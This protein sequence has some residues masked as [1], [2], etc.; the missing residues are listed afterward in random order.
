MKNQIKMEQVIYTMAGA[1]K[2]TDARNQTDA[3]AG[4]RLRTFI[5]AGWMVVLLLMLIS[6]QTN[7][8]VLTSG[9]LKKAELAYREL[10]YAQAAGYYEAYISEN[11]QQDKPVLLN[12]ADCYWQMRNYPK[13]LKAYQAVYPYGKEDATSETQYRMAE[14]YAYQGNY[15]Q[16]ARWLDHVKGYEAKAGAYKSSETMEALQKDS[17]PWKV[18]FLNINSGYRDFCPLV[19]DSVLLFSSNRPLAT[20]RKAYRWDNS[21]YTRLWMVPV[22]TLASGDP[23]SA[24]DLRPLPSAPDVKNRTKRFVSPF[25]GSDTPSSYNVSVASLDKLALQSLASL[26][27]TPV[28]GFNNQAFNAGTVAV[29]TEG[30]FYFTANYD[31]PDKS[32]TNRLRLMEGKWN[33]SQV[34][35]AKALPYGDSQTVSVMHPAVNPE[36]TVLIFSS[37]QK[38]GAGGYDLYFAQRSG[39]KDPW[40]AATIL[41]AN[42]N[43]GGNEVFPSISPDGYLYFSSDGFPGLGGLDIFRIR[44]SDAL[45]GKGTPV[46]LPSPVNSSA[47]DFGWTQGADGAVAYFTSDRGNSEDNIYSAAVDK[48]KL[49]KEIKAIRTVRLQGYVLDKQ[50]LKPIAGATV[51]LLN[52][53]DGKVYVAKSNSAGRYTY[54]LKSECVVVIKAVEK[55]FSADCL[56]MFT[57]FKD[58]PAD[59]ALKAS[60]DL[61][62]DKFITGYKWQL[63]NIHYDF[64]KWNIRADA[65]PILDSLVAFLKKYPVKVELGSHTDCRGSFAYNDRLSQHRAEAAVAYIVSKGI[66]P[67]RITAKGYGE[68]QLLNRCADGVKCSEAEHQANRRTEVKVL[69]G[70]DPGVP[71]GFDPSVYK[72]GQQIEEKDLPEN[73]FGSC[74]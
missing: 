19:A 21:E 39:S 71:E 52:Q 51:F 3:V 26:P 28:A 57:Q 69:M 46:H 53:C 18:G 8:R 74:K 24:F 67:S 5:H 4:S 42:V 59:S 66:D 34:S 16:A 13:A 1:D 11:A 2:Y 72:D 14:L 23:E 7:A 33:G 17:I 41:G 56:R 32:G 10:R 27:G 43:T 30:H 54:T 61:L 6:V 38:D 40:G 55:N 29:D 22:S 36:G 68:R 35:S 25:E 45:S 44:L 37:K 60:K 49:R 20:G 73:F 63:D 15:V 64:D 62:L 12:L 48:D 9:V 31:T 65:R 70:L 58:A 47:D 50:S